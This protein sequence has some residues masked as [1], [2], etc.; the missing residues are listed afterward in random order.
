MVAESMERLQ[1]RGTSI[2]W[3]IGTY[4]ENKEILKPIE[5]IKSSSEK[6][7]DDLFKSLSNK[8]KG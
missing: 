6:T 7:V 2:T 5:I 4:L 3:T 8:L 1:P